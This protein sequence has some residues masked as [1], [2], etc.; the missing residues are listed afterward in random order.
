MFALFVILW[1]AAR[2]LAYL[3]ICWSVYAHMNYQAMFYGTYSLRDAAPGSPNSGLRISEDGG[4]N[5]WRNVFQVF[6]NPESETLQLNARIKFGFLGLLLALQCITLM[7]FVMICRVVMKVLRGEGADDT[8]SDDEDGDSE[9]EDLDLEEKAFIEIEAEASELN[10]AGY[11][12]SGVKRVGSGSRKTKGFSSGLNL[13]DRK[14][15]LNRIGCLSEE[16]L[17]REREKMGESLGRPGSR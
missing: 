13:G 11:G 5:V 10:F 16:Q 9:S 7:W 17:V 2:H 15:I 3:N 1:F 4:Q 8:R 14:D 6:I 12:G